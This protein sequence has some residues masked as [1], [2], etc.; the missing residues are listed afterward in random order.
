MKTSSF[1]QF[2]TQ[3]IEEQ[4]LSVWRVRPMYGGFSTQSSGGW[5]DSQQ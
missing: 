1:S 4:N 3:K 5:F 2:V